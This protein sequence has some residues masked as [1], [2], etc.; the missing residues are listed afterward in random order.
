MSSEFA[1]TAI[2]ADEIFLPTEHEEKRTTV[3]ES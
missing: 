2:A 1:A 3:Y